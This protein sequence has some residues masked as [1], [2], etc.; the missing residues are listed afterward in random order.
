MFYTEAV[1]IVFHIDESANERITDLQGEIDSYHDAVKNADDTIASLDL[2]ISE[3][4]GRILTLQEKV[5]S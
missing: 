2:I 5:N 4:S 3:Y 1:I